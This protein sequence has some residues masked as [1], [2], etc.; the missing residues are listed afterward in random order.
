MSKILEKM[1]WLVTARPYITLLVILIIT[2]LLAA[3]ATRR[4]PPPETAARLPDGSAITEAMAEIDV[5]F[6]DSGETSVVTLLFR[7]EVITPEGLS[8]M[9]ALINDIVSNAE[10]GALLAWSDPVIAPTSIIKALLQVDSFE[11]VTQAKIDAAPGPPEMKAALS[12]LTGTDTDGTPVSIDAVHL[13]HG[14]EQD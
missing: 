3:G 12:A 14:E 1:G 6:G 11:S 4:A 9:D 13:R 2:V 8:Q 7:G 5:L 10:V